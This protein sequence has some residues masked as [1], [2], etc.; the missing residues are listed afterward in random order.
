MAVNF[1]GS[2]VATGSIISTTGF[3]GSLSGTASYAL[4]AN[5][6]DGKDSST[7]ATTGSNIFVGNQTITGSFAVSGSTTQIGNNTL[8]GNTTLS[9]SIIISGSVGA[10]ADL[11][12][13]GVLRF[14]SAID[15]GASNLTASYLFTSASNTTTGHDL[16][17][18]QNENLVKFK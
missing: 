13:G 10:K 7:F 14:D 16:Y 11:N 6:L 2:L 17:Y 8:I 15:P 5:L 12:L 4:D 18:R 9:G 1:S 3:T